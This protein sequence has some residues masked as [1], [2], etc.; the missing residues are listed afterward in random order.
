MTDPGTLVIVAVG[1]TEAD[2]LWA[3]ETAEVGPGRVCPAWDRPSAALRLGIGWSAWPTRSYGW[4]V[5]SALPSVMWAFRMAQQNLGPRL[6]G[7]VAN[8]P[9][10]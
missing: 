6:R 1:S 8:D 3:L 10:W 4:A 2:A 5:S 7:R 9:M